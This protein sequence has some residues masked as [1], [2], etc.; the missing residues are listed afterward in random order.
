[1][2]ILSIEIY[3][4]NIAHHEVKI[5]D[6]IFYH[7]K[8]EVKQKMENATLCVVHTQSTQTRV[9]NIIFV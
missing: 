9:L 5:P 4:W 2:K 6:V 1:M 8:N 7:K 3:I